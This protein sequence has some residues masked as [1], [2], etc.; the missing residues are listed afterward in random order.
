ML[1]QHVGDGGV[2]CRAVDGAVVG[3]YVVQVDTSRPE[4]SRIGQPIRDSALDLGA[5]VSLNGGSEAGAFGFPGGLFS[6]TGGLLVA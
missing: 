6:C 3:Q 1:G 5:L 4:V 2:E